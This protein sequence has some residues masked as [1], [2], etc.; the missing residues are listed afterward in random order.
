MRADAAW[1]VAE[2]AAS[3]CSAHKTVG[4]RADAVAIDVSHKKWRRAGG[5]WITLFIVLPGRDVGP[6][7]CR[8]P[9]QTWTLICTDATAVSL[10]TER[11]RT[12]N[13]RAVARFSARGL[14]DYAAAGFI[15]RLASSLRSTSAT[16]ASR[17]GCLMP[18]CFA[19][20]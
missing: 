20:S 16:I 5:G 18:F 1:D 17:A 14:P 9:H 13:E 7:G 11:T 8:P 2:S 3:R 12:E 4:A 15:F 19:A 10:P 6:G